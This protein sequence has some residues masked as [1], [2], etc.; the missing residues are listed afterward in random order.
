MGECEARTQG[1]PIVELSVQPRTRHRAVQRGE[2]AR[3]HCVRGSKERVGTI[4]HAMAEERELSLQ[5]Q[6]EGIGA[7][8]DWVRGYL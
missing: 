8:L 3:A 4:A 7:Q 6:L 1:A 2:A 5:E